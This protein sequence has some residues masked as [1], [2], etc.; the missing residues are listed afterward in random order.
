MKPQWSERLG[1]RGMILFSS[2]A[3]LSVLLM[4][5]IGARVMLQNDYRVLSNLRGSTEAFYLATAGLEWSKYEIARVAAFPP[6]PA[7]RSENFAG[8]VFAV[9]FVSID[10]IS[11]VGAKI[12]VRVTGSLG[13]FTH[14]VQA[15]LRKTYD[16]ADAALGLRGTG[17]QVILSGGAILVSGR[18][19][20][21][22]TAGAIANVKSRPAISAG[23]DPMLGLVNQAAS[24]LSMGS[25]ESGAD[26]PPS[27]TSDYLPAST[28]IQLVNGLCSQPGVTVTPMPVGGALVFENQTWGTRTAPVL[29]C[30][31]GLADPGDGVSLTGNVQGNGI[32]VVRNA[33]LVVSGSLRWE[34]L[35]IIAGSEV[36]FK[37]TGTGSKEIL[38][39]VIVDEIAASTSKAILDIQGNLRLL[40]SR[41][42]LAQSA[43]LI[44]PANLDSIYNHLPMTVGQDYWRSVTP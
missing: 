38:G 13:T 23:D 19:H 43:T 37:V 44:L 31:E 22:V 40:F 39:A 29:R 36:S 5:G 28:L 35:I 32:L 12:L 41:Q 8:G 21:P 42:A 27:A 10:Q 1:D 17:S 33:D 11:P 16:L 34:G 25:L 3:I 14:S 24:G 15:Q 18:D 6:A 7:D 30:I 4:V 20:D 9:D 2:L 26:T